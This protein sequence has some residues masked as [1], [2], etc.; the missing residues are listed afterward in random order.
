[1]RSNYRNGL[2]NLHIK[3]VQFGKSHCK[4]LK[5]GGPANHPGLFL[6]FNGGVNHA[7]VGDV[8]CRRFS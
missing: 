8:N 6:F 1:M 3:F 4:L 5:F 2:F 7:T